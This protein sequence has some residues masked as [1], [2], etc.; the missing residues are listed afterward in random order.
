MDRKHVVCVYA[1]F[2]GVVAPLILWSV[3]QDPLAKALG[4]DDLAAALA[5]SCDAIVFLLPYFLR[6]W[7]KRRKILEWKRQSLGLH[8]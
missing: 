2:M 4:S 6:R 5:L 7:A 8:G 3:F 1:W